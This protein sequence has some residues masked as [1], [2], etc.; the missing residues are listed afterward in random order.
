MKQANR[1]RHRQSETHRLPDIPREGR[2]GFSCS[3]AIAKR[4]VAAYPAALR[5]FQIACWPQG[6]TE[7]DT[8]EVSCE[9]S[10]PMKA[11]P[12]TLHTTQPTKSKMP[13]S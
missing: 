13:C 10:T 12:H 5:L 7:S 4:D 6:Q 11:H 1:A 9:G 8:M 2:N 3:R